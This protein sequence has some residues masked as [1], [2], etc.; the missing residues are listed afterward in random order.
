M[1]SLLAQRQLMLFSKIACKDHAL[2]PIRTLVFNNADSFDP[3]HMHWQRKRGRPRLT[4][5]AD[6]RKLALNILGNRTNVY[7]ILYDSKNCFFIW[8]RL[9]KTY[10]QVINID[11]F[12]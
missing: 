4:W 8:T 10:P 9:V 2:N 1:S 5:I 12:L 3:P 6:V 7:H 11:W